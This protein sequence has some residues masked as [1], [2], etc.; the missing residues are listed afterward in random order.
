M[1]SVITVVYNAE[2]C[3]E[4][5]IQSVINQKNVQLEYVIIDGQS[6]D[7]TLKIIHQYKDNIDVL[8]SEKDNGI[9]DAM[10]KGVLNSHG[11]WLFFLNAGDIFY[12]DTVLSDI[13]SK[14]CE[15]KDIIYGNVSGYDSII[16]KSPTCFNKK[17]VLLGS[18]ICHQAILANRN[19]FTNNFFSLD[20]KIISDRIWLYNALKHNASLQY[21]DMPITY[22]D[23]TG[24]SMN[25]KKMD[26][27]LISYIK[28]NGFIWL[29]IFLIRKTIF[30]N[31]KKKLLRLTYGK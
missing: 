5:T 9:Y 30:W 21:I 13:I 10:N 31:A 14:N 27:E 6:T 23:M 3:I 16:R 1:I 8:I 18:M 25:V 2:R 4:K 29:F 22:Y 20:Y 12:T 11:E 24:V 19:T 26:T 15:K 28:S 17:S 7:S